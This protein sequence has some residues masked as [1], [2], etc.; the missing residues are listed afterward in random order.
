MRKYK[1]GAKKGQYFASGAAAK[2]LCKGQD[3]MHVILRGPDGKR[4][5]LKQ[6]ARM[7]CKTLNDLGQGERATYE[8]RLVAVKRVAREFEISEEYLRDYCNDAIFWDLGMQD[9]EL[10]HHLLVW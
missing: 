7:V 1:S 9:T 6:L 8:E 2:R 3:Y 4:Y 5:G 10:T